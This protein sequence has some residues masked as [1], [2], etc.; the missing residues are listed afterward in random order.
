MSG[1]G[2]AGD[3]LR[4]APRARDRAP[5]SDAVV[6][7]GSAAAMP[8]ARPTAADAGAGVMLRIDRLVLDGPPLDRRQSAQLQAALEHELGALLRDR[9][10]ASA[11]QSLDRLRGP[12]LAASA[13]GA[14][15]LGQAIARSLHAGLAGNGARAE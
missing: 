11:A 14:A 4:R 2:A 3:V 7:A 9:P 12:P 10:L 1:H 15:G 8:A 6:R 13:S 5:A